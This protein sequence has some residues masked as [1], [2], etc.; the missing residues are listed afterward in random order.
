M[1]LSVMLSGSRRSNIHSDNM[2]VS[3]LLLFDKCIRT[4]VRIFP[5]H[6]KNQDEWVSET[7]FASSKFIM[8]NNTLAQYKLIAMIFFK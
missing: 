3:S 7:L 5:K 2:L 1:W 6:R 4:S 8:N